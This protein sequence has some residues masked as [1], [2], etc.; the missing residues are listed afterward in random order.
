MIHTLLRLWSRLETLLI[1]LCIFAALVCFL[2]GAV[3]R[4]VAPGHAVDWAEEVSLYFI[5][6]ATALSGSALVAERRHIFTE[7]FVSQLTRPWRQ[8][9]GWAITALTVGFCAAMTVFGWQAFE[10]ALLLDERS[11]ST[12]RVQQGYAL[13]LALPV[14]MALILLRIAAMLLVGERPFRFT[15][16]R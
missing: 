4:A 14:G 7:I 10:F 2:G 16:G 3:L 8:A 12:L 1:G 13:F 5:I 9:L 6:W 11:A 15:E